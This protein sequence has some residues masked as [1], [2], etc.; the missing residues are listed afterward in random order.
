VLPT[1]LPFS[2]LRMLDWFSVSLG[3]SHY[4]GFIGMYA[5]E[6]RPLR[7]IRAGDQAVVP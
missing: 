4:A 3:R 6:G 2:T 1:T 5:Q 7:T